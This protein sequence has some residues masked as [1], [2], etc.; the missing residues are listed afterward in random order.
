MKPLCTTTPNK[1]PFP[2]PPSRLSP[3]TWDKMPVRH[4]S[5]LI[6]FEAYHLAATLRDIGAIFHTPV[7]AIVLHHTHVF[8][9]NRWTLDQSGRHVRIA[10][11]NPTGPHFAHWCQHVCQVFGWD[12]FHYTLTPHRQV[13]Y[14][15]RVV[16]PDAFIVP[17]NGA[18]AATPS[19]HPK[20]LSRC[21]HGIALDSDCYECTLDMF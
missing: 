13:Y 16:D 14:L 6:G 1:A 11:P 9:N 5:D 20:T 21:A 8:R 4:K 12:A 2:L 19:G 10:C 15:G 7:S 3:T 18:D 17:S